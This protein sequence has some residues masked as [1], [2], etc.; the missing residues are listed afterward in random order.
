MARVAIRKPEPLVLRSLTLTDRRQVSGIVLGRNSIA[1]LEPSCDMFPAAHLNGLARENFAH[2]HWPD[3]GATALPARSYLRIVLSCRVHQP[4]SSVR[5][6]A[7]RSSLKLASS[8]ALSAKPFC[9][10]HQGER[11]H[12]DRF[13]STLVIPQGAG[14]QTPPA[15]PS[16][17][18]AVRLPRRQLPRLQGR[19]SLKSSAA[20]TNLTRQTIFS[21]GS[22]R[23]IARSAGQSTNGTCRLCRRAC[24]PVPASS[25]EAR[26]RERLRGVFFSQQRDQDEHRNRKPPGRSGGRRRRRVSIR[27]AWGAATV[28]TALTALPP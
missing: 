9:E 13:R 15:R 27:R 7:Y 21:T 25:A 20:W 14:T 22:T 2:R 11:T 26:F 19:S 8:L 17:R 23:P 28:S 18:F 4:P 5:D 1:T 10:P 16:D 24:D 3:H 6:T 12:H